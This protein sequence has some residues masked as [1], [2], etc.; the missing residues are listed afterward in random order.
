VRRGRAPVLSI[1]VSLCLFVSVLP[2]ADDAPDE[3]KVTTELLKDSTPSRRAE[4]AEAL[5]EK[6]EPAIDVLIE[7]MKSDEWRISWTAGDVLSRMKEP[8]VP[9]LMT[10]L[11]KGGPRV[12]A[13][14]AW[15]LGRIGD[16]RAAEPLVRALTDEKWIVAEMAGKALVRIGV[17]AVDALAESYRG[18]NLQARRLAGEALTAIPGD[19]ARAALRGKRHRYWVYSSKTPTAKCENPAE[20]LAAALRNR[21]YGEMSWALRAVAGTKDPWA[22]DPLMI[23]VEKLYYKN[24]LTPALR[25]LRAYAYEPLLLVLDDPDWGTRQ[26]A[27]IVL[28][29]MGDRR[30]LEPLT[31]MLLEDDTQQVRALAALSLGDLGDPR[32][33][34]ALVS[35]LGDRFGSIRERAS[36]ALG[37][38]E[39]PEDMKQPAIEKLKVLAVNDKYKDVR[40]AAANAL[41]RI[42]GRPTK[43]FLPAADGGTAE[44]IPVPVQSPAPTP[45]EPEPKAVEID[46]V[47]SRVK[48]TARKGVEWLLYETKFVARK[49]KGG[50][51]NFDDFLIVRGMG[52]LRT[53]QLAFTREAVWAATEAGAYCY[54]RKNA[55]WVEYAVNKEHIGVPVDSVRVDGSGRIVFGMKVDGRPRTYTLDPKTSKWENGE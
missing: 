51:R 32:A 29:A 28:G 14:A 44:K 50:I 41:H 1:G 33:A 19:E 36:K 46:R 38:I 2:A 27:G 53:K 43:K 54:E 31:R 30:A 16:K 26:R 37:M 49:E 21:R 22:V 17:P 15:A 48:D 10:E 12:K 35:V 55:A 20:A 34:K 6:G 13:R 52:S 24:M 18:R 3:V 23:A 8:A 5:S 7:C 4:I 25:A 39:V 42:T 47:V 11:E 9:A 40:L 45:G